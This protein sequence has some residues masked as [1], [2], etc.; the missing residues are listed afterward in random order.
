M[1]STPRMTPPTRPTACVLPTRWRAT[2][3]R[4]A[5]GRACLRCPRRARATWPRC[6]TACCTWRAAGTSTTTRPRR[7]GPP[8]WKRWTCAT[9]TRG[10]RSIDA[11]FQLRG[12]GVAAASGQLVVVGGM[13]PIGVPQRVTHLFDPSD[14]SWTRGPELPAS[15][16]GAAAA[17]VGSEVVVTGMDGVVH[18]LT[19]GEATW[20][21]AGSVLFPRF[22]HQNVAANGQVFSIGGTA[23]MD[24]NDRI[25]HVERVWPAPAPVLLTVDYTGP[26]KNRQG[27]VIVDDWL[28]LFGGN[29]SHGQH[30]FAPEN[31]SHDARRLHLP[32]LRWEPAR[33]LSREPAD[34][35][36][37][38]HRRHALRV[39]GRLRHPRCGRRGRGA[40]RVVRL[41]RDG[42]HVE[43]GACARARAHPVCADAR[44]R[45]RASRDGGP[46]LRPVACGHGRLPAPDH[47]GA[48]RAGRHRVHGRGLCAATRAAGLRGRGAGRALLHGGRHARQLPA[49]ERVRG[50]LVHHARLHAHGVPQRDAPLATA[51]GPGRAPGAGGAAAW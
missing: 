25:P 38:R 47:G 20:R 22:F 12:V 2:T 16:F 37:D 5:A 50:A 39:G 11:P 26:T 45:R 4:A 31:F 19:P 3:S 8:P 23:G 35:G 42:W 9:R 28:Y 43:P 34:H 21:S 6:W 44:S 15:P 49:G 18:V 1:R 40:Q 41:R 17:A 33:T 13:D 30:D 32:T 46:E 24:V 29:T 36:R 7:A 48:A 51:G 10:W 27:M 14:A